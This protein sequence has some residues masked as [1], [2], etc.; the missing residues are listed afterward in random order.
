MKIRL[1]NNLVV[2]LFLCYGVVKAGYDLLAEE[3]LIGYVETDLKNTSD[4]FA[5]LVTGDSM[6]P[7]IFENDIVIVQKQ[8][9]IENGQVAVVIVDDEATIKKVIV[10][11]DC[12]ELIAFN[13]YYPPRKV[14]DFTIVG[15]VVEARIK[16][17]FE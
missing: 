17:I 6:S 2:P 12:I 11:E 8:S 15:R 7:I 16:K 1:K 4:F 13:S 14:K 5:L 10:H 3:N 9:T